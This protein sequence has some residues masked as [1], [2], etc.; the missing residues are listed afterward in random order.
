MAGTDSNDPEH[1]RIALAALNISSEITGISVDA[2][3]YGGIAD[4]YQGVRMSSGA[5]GPTSVA[6]KFIRSNKKEF[7]TM[8]RRY[9]RE[10]RVWQGIDHPNVLPL[11][12]LYWGSRQLPALVSPWC[13]HG[14]ISAYL[15]TLPAGV[16]VLQRKHVSLQEI[17]RGLA[18]RKHGAP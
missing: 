6:I 9:R 13:E 8:L 16:D 15:Q 11:L 2:C 17:A 1:L 14:S 18:Y 12:G 3:R 5:S 4:I 10:I 7:E